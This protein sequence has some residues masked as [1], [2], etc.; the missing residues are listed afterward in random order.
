M[1]RRAPRALPTRISFA[2]IAALA[3]MVVAVPVGTVFPR[4][5]ARFQDGLTIFTGVLVEALPFILLGVIVSAL[6]RRFVTPGIIARVVPKHPVFAYPVVA[7]CGLALPVCECGNLPVA[8]QLMRQ[9]LRPSQALTFLLSAPIINPAVIISTLAAFSWMPGVLWARLGVGFFVAVT[10]GWVFAWLGDRHVASK[11]ELEYAQDANELCET[12]GCADGTCEHDHEQGHSHANLAGMV[13]EFLEMVSTVSIGAVIAGVVQVT[14]PRSLLLE[15][16]S[17][18][19]MAILVMMLLALIVSLCSNVDAF[20]ALSFAN[21]FAPS[22]LVA[23]LVFGPMIDFRALALFSRSFSP[24][25]IV[26]MT[27]LVGQLVFLATLAL[28]YL[29]II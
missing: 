17:N 23:F 7:A 16:A 13:D 11:A 28:H 29:G 18:P 3:A 9:G 12:C 21:T 1:V 24:R 19:A 5:P 14:V 10:V 8:R 26:I 15:F 2:V 25:T 20:F 6:I 27:L 4:L 22:A